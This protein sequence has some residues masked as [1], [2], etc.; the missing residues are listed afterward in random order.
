M[1]LS[2]QS[3]I[4]PIDGR[5]PASL[6]RRPKA[7]FPAKKR[8]VERVEHELFTHVSGHRPADDTTA[9]NVEYN[10]Q[11]QKAAKRVCR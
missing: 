3:P 2:S 10:G 1:A 9:E 8:H 11:V 7:R 5:T 6:Q 4:D